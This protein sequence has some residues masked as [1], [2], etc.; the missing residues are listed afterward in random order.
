MGN[1]SSKPGL[2]TGIK[3]K[4]VASKEKWAREGRLIT[5][6]ADERRL[7]RLPPGQREVKNWPVLDL[8]IQPMLPP[9]RWRLDVD[10]LVES[11]VHWTLDDFL[12]QPRLRSQ[13]D[14]HCVTAWSRYDNRWEGVAA[15]HIMALVKPKPEAKHVIFHSFDGYTTNIPLD[16]FG[17]ENALLADR[18]EGEPITREHGGPVRVVV[19]H[20]YFW[21]SAKW[22]KRI[23]FAAEDRPGFWEV[24]GYHNYGDPWKEE[25]YS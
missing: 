12:A 8:G 13:S 7:Q 15:R 18:W 24:R 6:R 21:K 23:E 3:D 22:V 10:G 1:D 20:L 4:L 19:P 25:R 16:D 11:P 9:S 17:V 14:I 2:M 5:G